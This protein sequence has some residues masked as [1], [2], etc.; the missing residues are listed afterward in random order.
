M[1]EK[2]AVSSR[3][4]WNLSNSVDRIAL[5]VDCTKLI[6]QYHNQN[7]VT[8]HKDNQKHKHSL[9]L[10]HNKCKPK[11]KPTKINISET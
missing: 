5:L 1:G 4:A 3:F 7:I 9:K 6:V 11:Y 10:K 8:N 2:L